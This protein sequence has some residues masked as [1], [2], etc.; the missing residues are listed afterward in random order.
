MCKCYTRPPCAFLHA[1]ERNEPVV[2]LLRVCYQNPSKISAACIQNSKDFPMQQVPVSEPP[3]KTSAWVLP[4]SLRAVDYTA[5]LCRF[6]SLSH[7][8]PRECTGATDCF[9]FS[10]R[11][12]DCM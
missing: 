8:I 4:R 6:S 12:C 10:I 5:A 7:I 1:T 2:Q 9:I 11:K 3:V